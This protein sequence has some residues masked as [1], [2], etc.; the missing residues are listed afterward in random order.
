MQN[1]GRTTK[2]AWCW[3][4]ARKWALEIVIRPLGRSKGTQLAGSRWPLM[5]LDRDTR[6]KSISTVGVHVSYD[7]LTVCVM[8]IKV[9]CTSEYEHV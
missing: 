3:Y 6:P 9:L 7:M 2:K 4:P 1:P 5:W 8:L